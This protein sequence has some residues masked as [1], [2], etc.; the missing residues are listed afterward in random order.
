[1]NLIFVNYQIPPSTVNITKFPVL[2]L[3]AKD[4]LAIP[5]STVASESAFS[6]GGRVLDSFRSSLTPKVVEALICGQDWIRAAP[7]PSVEENID[8][9]EKLE[10]FYADFAAVFPQIAVNF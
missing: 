2:S 9:V 10:V 5:V 8:D 3:I 6:V 7:L 4:V 1:M